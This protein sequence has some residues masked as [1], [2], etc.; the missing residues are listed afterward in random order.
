MRFEDILKPEDK[1]FYR[2]E[3]NIKN[4]DLT[5]VILITWK[6]TYYITTFLMIFFLFN[7]DKIEFELVRESVNLLIAQLIKALLIS[8][9]CILILML[10]LGLVLVYKR[11]KWLS[12]KGY[13]IEYEKLKQKNMGYKNG[14]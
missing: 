6:I 9:Y 3:F 4:I 7:K 13:M 5:F 10:I 12:K 8:S 14:K 1:E 11:N 2:K